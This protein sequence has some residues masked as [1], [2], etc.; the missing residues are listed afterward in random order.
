MDEFKHENLCCQYC[1]AGESQDALQT[2]GF[3]TGKRGYRPLARA[4][5]ETALREVDLT[6]EGKMGVILSS[7]PPFPYPSTARGFGGQKPERWVWCVLQ[8]QQGATEEMAYECLHL[9]PAPILHNY[10]H[11]SVSTPTCKHTYMCT[12]M[13]MS[14]WTHVWVCA[15]TCTHLWAHSHVWAHPYKHIA[16]TRWD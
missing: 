2:S 4:E 15:H 7:Y 14:Q 1:S 9:D 8:K 12:Y 10:Q 3:L 5:P 16:D 11:I 13:Q 6:E